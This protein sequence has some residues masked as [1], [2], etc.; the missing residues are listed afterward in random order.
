MS[1]YVL[2][3][4]TLADRPDAGK[5]DVRVSGERVSALG[6]AGSLSSRTIVDCDGLYALPGCI[7][8]HVHP[9]HNET[10]ASAGLAAPF[11][12]ITTVIHHLYPNRDETHA[13]AVRRATRE[14]RQ[15][16]ADF[17]LHLRITPDRVE[18]DYQ[19][20]CD[21]GILSIKVFLAHSDPSVQCSLGALYEVM[22]QA[23][24]VGLTVLV[25]AEFGD[26]IASAENRAMP[27]SNLAVF[28]SQRSAELEAAAVHAVC[29]IAGLTGC[30]IYFP[31][32]SSAA[33]L[34]EVKR[35][36]LLGVTVLMETCPHYL[37]LTAE[38]RLGG[39]GKVAPPLRSRGDV[40]T[41]R[42]AV[43]AGAVDTVASDHCGYADGDKHA[44]DISNSKNGL[45]GV[46]M[47]LSLLLDAAL[48]E[49]W[50]GLPDIVRVLAAGPAHAFQLKG[51]GAIAPGY[52]ADLVLI[53]PFGE[54]EVHQALLHDRSFYSPYEGRKMRGLIV[55]VIRRGSVLVRDNQLLEAGGGRFVTA[56]PVP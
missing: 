42:R 9:I 27:I 36:R 22:L 11:G 56:P 50:L 7:D 21:L 44:D 54:W 30:R 17:G 55:Q 32:I 8:A 49:G 31:H 6:C 41:L 45:P 38:S 43:V 12:G 29:A 51:K 39:L 4:L 13:E 37:F 15:A 2:R 35:A 5:Q 33:A 19:L 40:E 18:S 3:G 16:P 28:S 46:E 34:A 24:R 47:L 10:F 20:L 26:V 52:D 14:A 53:D 1:E 23:S 25:H 48:S